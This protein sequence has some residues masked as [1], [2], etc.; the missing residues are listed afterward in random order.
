MILEKEIPEMESN[1]QAEQDEVRQT[2][3]QFH[4]TDRAVQYLTA[5]TKQCETDAWLW[6]LE[7]VQRIGEKKY[8][9]NIST[10]LE[11]VPGGA[12]FRAGYTL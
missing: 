2:F 1:W 5:Y 11:C 3:L 6:V 8:S 12:S 9:E 4:D 10:S 7:M